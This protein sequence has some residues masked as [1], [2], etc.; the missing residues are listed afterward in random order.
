MERTCYIFGAGDYGAMG[1][2]EPEAGSL[3][4]AADGGYDRLARWGIAPHLAVGDFDSLGR[5]PEGVAVVRHPAE[6]DD[7]DMALAVQEGLDRGCGRFLL[8]GGLGGRLDHT[9]ANLHLLSALAGAGRRAFL[10]GEGCAVTAVR[11]GALAFSPDFRGTLSLFAWGGAAEGV[12]LTGL[13]YPLERGALL[14]D[15]PLG[16]SNE[17]LGR[18]A[19]V[20]VERGTLLALWTRPDLL[21]RHLD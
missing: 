8:Y 15:R 1:R 16:V 21:P 20:R 7:T 6:K 11:G 17:F 2:P 13:K 19:L 9:L 4:I 3:V 14:P 10:L 5:V 18:E 12:T